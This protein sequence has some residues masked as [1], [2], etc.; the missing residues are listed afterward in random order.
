MLCPIENFYVRV[1]S[2]LRGMGAIYEE[3]LMNASLVVR[4]FSRDMFF[5]FERAFL[6]QIVIMKITKINRKRKMH[7]YMFVT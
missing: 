5:S 3:L 1:Q 4:M 7:L 6:K 2:K